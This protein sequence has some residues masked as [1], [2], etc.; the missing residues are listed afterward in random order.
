MDWSDKMTAAGWVY[1]DDDMWEL[2][3]GGF[4][5]AMDNEES[6]AYRTLNE[7]PDFWAFFD[8]DG[9]VSDGLVG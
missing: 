6:Q 5:V 7:L 1:N 8:E 4:S 3:N 2:S 9:E